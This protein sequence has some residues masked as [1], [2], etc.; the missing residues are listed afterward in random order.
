MN[1]Q[2]FTNII[3]KLDKINK[4]ILKTHNV[5]TSPK[6]YGFPIETVILKQERNLRK[7]DTLNK[8]LEYAYIQKQIKR[9]I[10]DSY[11]Y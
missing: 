5:L 10:T 3:S 6:T 11:W 7:W 8:K 4:K 1:F 9:N 2:R